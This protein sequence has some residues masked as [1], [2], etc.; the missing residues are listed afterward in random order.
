M[1]QLGS[2]VL[3]TVA[4]FAV[5]LS[6]LVSIRIFLQGHDL[7]GGGFIAGV[8]AAAAGAIHLLAFGAEGARRYPWWRLAVI[9]L[10]VSLGTGAASWLRGGAFMDHTIW[11]FHAPLLGHVHLPTATFFDLGVYL[12]VL[13][14]LMTFFLELAEES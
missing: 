4:R 7:P 8:L 1:S 9:G 13:G 2:P 5:P 14:T 11:D 6:V 10:L 12:I 3:R